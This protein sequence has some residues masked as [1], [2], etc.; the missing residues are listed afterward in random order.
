MQNP[1]H[2]EWY[3]MG[4]AFGELTTRM[5]DAF[6]VIQSRYGK[7]APF[8][9]KFNKIRDH[10]HVQTA[11]SLDSAVCHAV[12]GHSLAEPHDDVFVTHVFYRLNRGEIKPNPPAVRPYPKTL[13]S[14]QLAN[15][16][17][18]LKDVAEFLNKVEHHIENEWCLRTM[19]RLLSGVFAD[20]SLQF[21]FQNIVPL[22]RL[23]VN[24]NINKRQ[25]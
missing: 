19:K 12:R 1:S 25:K 13:L 9:K 8:C 6:A 14:H 15:T 21:K 22:I 10:F 7:S 5:W 4:C 3:R 11:S 23:F 2:E 24:P 16:R 18:V 17:Q 20:D